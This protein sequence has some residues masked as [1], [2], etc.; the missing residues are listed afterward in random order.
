MDLSLTHPSQMY[1][2]ANQ[3]VTCRKVRDE[4]KYLS[5]KKLKQNR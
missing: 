5:I 1:I 2:I 3:G 4:G